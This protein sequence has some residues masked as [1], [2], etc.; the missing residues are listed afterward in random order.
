MKFMKKK[1]ND[2]MGPRSSLGLL[3]FNEHS[4]SIIKLTPELV[5]TISLVFGVLILVLVMAF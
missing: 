4:K 3:S 2:G 5:I 1:N